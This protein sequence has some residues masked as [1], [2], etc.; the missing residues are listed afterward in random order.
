MNS[1]FEKFKVL[2]LFKKV[3]EKISNAI[4]ALSGTADFFSLCMQEKKFMIPVVNCYPFLTL[5]GNVI[6]AWLLYWQA[7]IADAKLS[8]IATANKMDRSSA[9]FKKL[10]EENNEASFYSS[11]ILTAAFFISSILPQ[12]V[13]IRECIEN[14][15]LSAIK[16][17]EESF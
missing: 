2:N 4:N 5:T 14:S 9:E 17:K 15:D 13:A 12:A 7:G 10:I 11:K 3:S 16:M 8:E 6:S 1:T